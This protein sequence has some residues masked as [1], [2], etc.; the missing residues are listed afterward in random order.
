MKIFKVG[1]KG[2]GVC[3]KCTSFVDTTY[4]LRDVSFSD[5]SGIVKNILVGVCDC[6]DSVVALP[7]QSTPA[8]KKQLNF[9]KL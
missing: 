3:Y 9:Q 2:R 4:N 6:C 7:H 8:V 5:G 1:D